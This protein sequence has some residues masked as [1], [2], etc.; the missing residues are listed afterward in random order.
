VATVENI[1]DSAYWIAGILS[2]PV[3]TASV[4]QTALALSELNDI[5]AQKR[6]LPWFQVQLQELSFAATTEFI[7]IG[8]TVTSV[9]TNVTVV[10]EPFFSTILAATA[11][12][13][14]SR[15]VLNIFPYSQAD[16]INWTQSN[17]FPAAIYYGN[18]LDDENNYYTKI[19]VLP[20]STSYTFNLT[21]IAG[22]D[23]YSSESDILLN[24]MQQYLKYELSKR[25]AGLYNSL[26]EWMQ[27]NES[28]RLSIENEFRQQSTI[29]LRPRNSSRLST[30]TTST[31]STFNW[32]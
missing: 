9:D 16:N 12:Q 18:F 23:D 22:L 7:F 6:R 4:D 24:G 13:S 10:N 15:Y 5:V 25:L 11:R 17:G 14:T 28:T 20:V 19:Q 31:T 32:L 2:P 30:R 26:D 1:V 27:K 3:Q 29:V 21:G 8:S